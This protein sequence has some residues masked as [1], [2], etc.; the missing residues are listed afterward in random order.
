MHFSVYS[1]HHTILI[2]PGDLET[3]PALWLSVVSQYKGKRYHLISAAECIHLAHYLTFLRNAYVKNEF[4]KCLEAVSSFRWRYINTG[5]VFGSLVLS[6]RH[7]LFL[8]CD[9]FMHQGSG[10][11]NTSSQGMMGAV[12]SVY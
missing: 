7:V 5:V 11:V 10:A 12:S 4:S 9:G 6:P 2:P 8:P 1:G 3:N